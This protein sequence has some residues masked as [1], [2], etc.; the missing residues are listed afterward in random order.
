MPAVHPQFFS[1]MMCILRC[2][3]LRAVALATVAQIRIW[4]SGCFTF[5]VMHD[6]LQSIVA[7]ADFLHSHSSPRL[8]IAV[9]VRRWVAG[10]TRRMSAVAAILPFS[11]PGKFQYTSS[12]TSRTQHA[13]THAHTHTYM[14]RSCVHFGV[15]YLLGGKLQTA[16]RKLQTKQVQFVKQARRAPHQHT[17]V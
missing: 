17:E 16:N 2:I 5:Y 7:G 3:Y 11:P 10:R 12:S 14:Y 6:V 9:H 8:V 15:N 13:H 4:F 1:R